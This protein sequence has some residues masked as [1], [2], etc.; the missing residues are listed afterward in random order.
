MDP[1]DLGRHSMSLRVLNSLSKS[2]AAVSI[3]GRVLLNLKGGN[4]NKKKKVVI[5]ATKSDAMKKPKGKCFKCG[6]KGHWQQN[7]PKAT[8]FI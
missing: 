5:P 6:Q 2:Q 3:L 4:K 1:R 7:C 8:T